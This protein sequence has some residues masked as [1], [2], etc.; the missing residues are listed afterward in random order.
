MVLATYSPK[1][2]DGWLDVQPVRM[3]QWYFS[4]WVRS[5]DAAT[6]TTMSLAAWAAVPVRSVTKPILIGGRWPH[7]V[8]SGLTQRRQ[9]SRAPSSI[10][11]LVVLFMGPSAGGTQ[12]VCYTSFKYGRR[13]QGLLQD[14][15]RRSEGRRQDDQVRL[16]PAGPQVPSRRR[17]EQG[18][19]RP[20]QGDQ[21]GK[22]GA[23]RSGEAPPLRHARPRLAALRPAGSRSAGRRVPRRVPGRRWRRC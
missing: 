2:W 23:L 10:G 6:V 18:R 1:G 15:R 17:Q 7:V 11:N 12:I 14:P 8:P 13:V 9:I 21:R 4:R 5:S 19:D 16:P 3:T 22:R 20:L